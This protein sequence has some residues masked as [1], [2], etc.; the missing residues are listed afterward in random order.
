[1]RHLVDALAGV[2][3]PAALVDLD[4]LDRNIDRIRAQ[5]EPTGKTLRVASKSVRHVG[6]LRRILERGAPVFSG[7]MCFTCDEAVFLA[8]QGFDD[9]LVAYPTSSRDKIECLAAAPARTT[10]V[11]D[12]LEHVPLL[13]GLDVGAILEVDVSYRRVGQHLGSRRSPIRGGADALVVARACRDAGVQ[14]AGVMGYEGHIAGLPDDNPFARA[15]NPAK[16]LLKRLSIP[17]VA[18]VRGQVVDALRGDGFDVPL[19]NGGGTGSLAST[20]ADPSCTEMTA[21]SGFV[22]SHLFSWYAGTELEPAAYFALEVCRVS[23]PGYATCLGGGYIAS[24]EPGWDRV[25]LPVFPPGLEYVSIEG[26]GEVQ[27]P[28]RVPRGTSLS[29]GDTVLFRHAKAGELAERFS[30]YELV[31]GGRI[32]ASEPTYRGDGQ[33]FL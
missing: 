27:T 20:G 14:V 23:D 33:C 6:L 15:L 18:V 2:E 3:L 10:L 21:G 7:L 13:A 19:V 31:R 28:L 24:G 16:R 26:A 8:E 11:I 22:C 29:I 25:P 32:E 17:D 12:S 9:L 4:A 30:R 5:V 1:M